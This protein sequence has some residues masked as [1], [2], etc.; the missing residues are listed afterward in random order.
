MG[1]NRLENQAILLAGRDRVWTSC[2]LKSTSTSSLRG[3]APLSS[4]AVLRSA[5]HH[6]EDSELQV[7][8]VAVK[9]EYQEPRT[10]EYE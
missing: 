10:S 5:H 1:L 9:S 7:A 4:T 8:N 2:N 3:G 6:L